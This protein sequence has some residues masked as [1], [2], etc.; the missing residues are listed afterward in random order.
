MRLSELRGH[1]EALGRFRRA[2]VSYLKEQDSTVAGELRHEVLILLPSAEAAT[3]LTG[4]VELYPPPALAGSMPVRRGLS[5][6]VFEHESP[7]AWNPNL[8]HFIVDRLVQGE[9]QL[10]R[11]IEIEHKKRR[12]PLFWGDRLLRL[13]LGIPAYLVSLVVGVPQR[14]LEESSWGP[15]LRVIA[16]LADTAG[17]WGV[18][19]AVNWW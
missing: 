18:G 2:Y 10:A 11:A 6:L 15:V 1:Q 17:I 3:A 12:S 8:P 7:T 4:E 5:N 14:R 13:L 9:A 16:I 19:R